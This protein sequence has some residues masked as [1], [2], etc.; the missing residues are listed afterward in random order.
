MTVTSTPQ[1]AYS[2]AAVGT[3]ELTLSS[4]PN[5]YLLVMTPSETL[6]API[7]SVLLRTGLAMLVLMSAV[8]IGLL[9]VLRPLQGK[10][11]VHT[12]DLEEQVK[13]LQTLGQELAQERERL[14]QSNQELEQFAYAASHDLQQPLRMVSGFLDALRRQYGDK[15]DDNA[16]E[17]IGFAVDGAQR[18]RAMITDLLEYSRVGRMETALAPVNLS[19]TVEKAQQMLA[20]AIAEAQAEINVAPLPTVQAIEAQMV[21][22]FQNLLDNALKYQMPGR[23]PKISITAQQDGNHWIVRVTDNG[24]G[25]EAKSLERAFQL[26]QRLHPNLDCQGTGMG[27]AMCAKIVSRHQGRIWLESEPEQGTTVCISLPV[28]PS[29][30]E[31]SKNR[32]AQTPPQACTADSD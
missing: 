18:M 12:N 2:F 24:V 22:L 9:L 28:A 23:P 29:L 7:T 21:R 6:S 19:A 30:A 3:P 25:I 16:H 10:L 11:M 4:G 5:W 13:Q 1:W 8:G 27:L 32:S 14:H 26:F 31:S 20:L 15:L 17:F